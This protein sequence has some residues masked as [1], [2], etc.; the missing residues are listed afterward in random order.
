[1]RIHH[2][3]YFLSDPKYFWALFNCGSL[4]ERDAECCGSASLAQDDQGVLIRKR[5]S[6]LNFGLLN[7]PT[8]RHGRAERSSGAFFKNSYFKNSVRRNNKMEAFPN[9]FWSIRSEDKP[10]QE[11][12]DLTETRLSRVGYI[13][14]AALFI[15][16][17]VTDEL[18]N[19]HRESRRR[20]LSAGQKRI[21]VVESGSES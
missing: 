11:P 17:F 2:E 10:S 5:K 6:M 7:S 12:R 13:I 14:L 1:M 20:K 18:L 4:T 9:L 15:F 21:S 16:F 19:R 3:Y 8:P